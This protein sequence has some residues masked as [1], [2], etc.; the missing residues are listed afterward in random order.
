ML[1][2]LES[3]VNLFS[4]KKLRPLKY[5]TGYSL[6]EAIDQVIEGVDP[7]LRLVPGYQNKLERSVTD[8]LKHISSVVDQVP[9]PINISRK[10]FTSNPEV[11]AYFSTPD[12]LQDT[13]SCG[14]ELKT[15]FD[16]Q[17]N[18][19]ADAC[20]ALLC[21]DKK[22]IK[23]FGSA[24]KGDVIHRDVPQTSIS[25]FD[26]K[27][28]SP[29]INENEVRKGIKKCIFDGLVTHALQHIASIRIERSDLT[30][31]HRILHAKLRT[32]QSQGNGLSKLLAEAH[33]DSEESF[34]LETELKETQTRLEKM[35]GDKDILTFYLEEIIKILAEPEKFIQLNVA[36]FRLNDMGMI[37]DNNEQ[38]S[39]NVICFSE[40]EITNVM[41]RVVTIVCYNKEEINCTRK[42]G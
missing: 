26:Y 41:K 10:T 42:L 20:C 39:T 31:R 25:F 27:I 35:T 18:S 17:E 19:D 5:D 24:L 8:S 6:T 23:S 33:F 29:A 28:L 13:F 21:A 12:D 3:I 4:E 15:F 2:L 38:Q 7:K 14:T 11:R 9:G 30:H 40:L 37:I 34:K 36:C 16:L 1:K 22:E 32:R